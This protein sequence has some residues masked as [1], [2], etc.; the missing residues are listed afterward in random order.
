MG[1][2]IAAHLANAGLQV[3]LLDLPAR[4][5]PPDSLV[6]KAFR[7]ATRLSP[8][9][10]FSGNVASRIRLGNYEEHF[11]RLSDVDWIIE[12]V[13][14][15]M[16]VKRE[17][18]ARVERVAGKDAVISTNTSGLPIGEISAGRS[19][20][21]RR[22]FLGTHFF[23]PPR[24]L[25]LLEL[26]PTDDTDPTVLERVAQF[27]R[28]RL[29][30]GIVVARDTPNFIGNR[31]G[32]YGILQ[33]IRY[34]EEGDFTIE[35]IDALTGP[36]VGRP[37][38]ATFRTAD[39]VGLDVLRHVAENLY[40][41]VPNDESRDAFRPPDVLRSLVENGALGAKSGAGFYRKEAGEI[42]SIDPST[43]EYTT[44]PGTDPV[45]IERFKKA[46]ELDERIQALFGDEGRH[47]SFFRKTTVDLLAYSARRLGEITD[48]P[49]D[50]D[51]AMRWGFGWKMGPFEM[52]DTIGFERVRQ[53]AA[54]TGYDLPQWVDAMAGSGNRTFY[55]WRPTREIYLP[56][57]ERYEPEPDPVDTIPVAA[58]KRAGRE[59]WKI[60]EAALLDIGEGVVMFE[61]RSKAN[62]LGT[63]LIQ[64]LLECIDRVENDPDLRGMVIGN[65]GTHFSVGANLGEA[66][67]A[68]AEGR[69]DEVEK[70][71]AAFQQAVQRIRYASK[72]VVVAVHQ[73]ALGG[74]C[75]MAMACPNP[76]A[77]VESYLGLVELGAGLIP[78]GTGT[79][80]L[81]ALAARRS[82]SDFPSNVQPFLQRYFENVAMARVS[83]SAER[84]REMGY[85][86]DH[87]VLVMNDDR[88]LYS[89]REEVVRLS[90]QG[91][92]PP[93]VETE[94]L[95]LGRPTK[96][97]FE[98]AL[99]QYLAGAFISEYDFYLADQLAHVLTG[100]DITHPQT[101]HEQYLMDLEREVFMRLL[102]EKKTQ[103][104]IMHILLQNKP[105]R[106]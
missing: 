102:G 95:V 25:K 66:A 9:P 34:L 10:F 58:C 6:E 38:S 100:G 31:I 55:R 30:K 92:A 65:E 5:G 59:V 62:S 75:E 99:H 106:N 35:E 14:E 41:N 93:A 80:R 11:D 50:I 84:A 88:R 76:V 70:T 22:R 19:A 96:A 71:V 89:A 94:I 56:I 47:G 105:L 27:G 97:A 17:M 87:A 12:V 68:A 101:V 2:Q 1:S 23:N 32:V 13:V 63:R 83:T 91:Y 53:V 26:I 48:S 4:E 67:M 21:F 57:E 104:R 29:G 85:L 18:M 74:A 16:E 20:D 81:A 33:A 98:V 86:A 64:G 3:E 37:K 51:R 78:A 43:G 8:D 44:G 72:A 39:V 69:F 103:E 79:T 54:E 77:S 52:W 7:A 45:A 15:R 60:D 82:A 40:E 36:I 49:A 24:Y 90:N 46:G 42:R 61:F 73:R 28:V